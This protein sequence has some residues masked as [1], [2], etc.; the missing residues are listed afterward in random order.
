MLHRTLRLLLA[1]GVAAAARKPHIVS[2]GR[3]TKLAVLGLKMLQS[4]QRFQVRALNLEALVS[5]IGPLAPNPLGHS[6]G[7]RR[8]GRFHPPAE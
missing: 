7:Y 2:P 6:N 1:R 4:M 3:K 5:Q 8:R